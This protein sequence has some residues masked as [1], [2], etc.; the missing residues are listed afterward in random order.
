MV[1][2]IKN[3]C[4]WVA[5]SVGILWVGVNGFTSSNRN[6]VGRSAIIRRSA[7]T[8]SSSSSKHSLAPLE[9]LSP[10]D[11]ES[12]FKMSL[13]QN[14]ASPLSDV[15]SEKQRQFELKLGKVMDTLKKDYP[16][17]LKS[18]PDYSIYDDEID[19]IDPSGV[20][21]H[22]LKNYKGF[23]SLMHTVVSMFYCPQESRIQFKLAYDWAR[24][25]IRVSWNVVL[26]PRLHIGNNNDLYINGIS[27]YEMN[28]QSGLLTQHRVEHLLINNAPVTEAEGIF[29]T[30]RNM[31][32]N[33][34]S[35]KE[36]IPALN[37]NSRTS[38]INH[39]TANIKAEFRSFT[40]FNGRPTSILFSAAQDNGMEDKKNVKHPL[41]D[42]KAFDAKNKSRAKF[43]LKP[44]SPTEFV[45]IESQ[46]LE[47]EKVQ[48]TKAN[49]W[50]S[51]AE[52][53]SEGNKKKGSSWKDKMLGGLLKDTC[54]SNYD[55]V[56]PEVC[57]D[58]G[59]KKTCCA[60]GQKIMNSFRPDNGML[61]VPVV[62]SKYPR[63][64]P[65]GIPDSIPNN[66]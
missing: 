49:Q 39:A 3:T 6:N 31:A 59:F 66:Y 51:A 57:C 23:F 52:L 60:S 41:F 36:G 1:C 12:L 58:L 35:G 43:G 30:I 19:V 65:D 56:R 11:M 33:G 24:K 50:R 37:T 34:E 42:Q 4:G 40:N 2:Q 46:V 27:V 62:A 16:D 10:L 13:P 64:G 5:V 20:K 48:E 14:G 63:G 17:I 8:S 38:T 7:S 29:V 25:S 47:L 26:R 61:P 15:Q 54:E 44:I 21:L 9:S 22:S 32:T 55:C 45:E 18:D 28:T 53:A